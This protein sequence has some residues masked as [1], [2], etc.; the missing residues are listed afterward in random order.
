MCVSLKLCVCADEICL[1]YQAI[2]ASNGIVKVDV[3]VLIGRRSFIS[4]HSKELYA[5]GN[6]IIVTFHLLREIFTSFG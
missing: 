2:A 4:L 6:K 3:C 1:L 5:N